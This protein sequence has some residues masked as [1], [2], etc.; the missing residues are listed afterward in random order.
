MQT[1]GGIDGSGLEIA[2]HPVEHQPWPNWYRPSYRARPV[3]APFNVRIEPT[4]E[5]SGEPH[6]VAVALLGG[7]S[8]SR[9]RFLVDD[10]SQSWIVEGRLAALRLAGPPGEWFPHGAGV[11][12]AD[13]LIHIIEP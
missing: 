8:V 10:R 9:L 11:F 5:D 7:S 4:G 2:E 13:A 3:R 1:A 12:G 6:P